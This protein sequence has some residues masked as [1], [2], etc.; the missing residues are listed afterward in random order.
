MLN[1]A[2][3]SFHVLKAQYKNYITLKKKILNLHLWSFFAFS[4][5]F[6]NKQIFIGQ[7]D[8]LI[9]INIIKKK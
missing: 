3:R 1:G 5:C 2:I 7:F 6:F 4:N 8:L 9:E